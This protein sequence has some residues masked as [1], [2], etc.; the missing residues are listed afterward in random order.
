[1]Y[2]PA[3][4]ST[5]RYWITIVENCALTVTAL[6]PPQVVSGNLSTVAVWPPN[7]LL[8]AVIASGAADGPTRIA[9]PVADWKILMSTLVVPA[10]HD[11]P[12]GTIAVQAGLAVVCPAAQRVLV[13]NDVGPSVARV[14]GVADEG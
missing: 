10:A 2:T 7:G 9:S 4:V 3:G 5:H 13:G 8:H 6:R 14:V 11:H 12:V 1:M